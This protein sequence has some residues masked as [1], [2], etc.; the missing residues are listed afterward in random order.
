MDR[1]AGRVAVVTGA[2]GGIGS[3]IAK[4]LVAAGLVV[5]GVDRREQPLRVRPTSR[6]EVTIPDPKSALNMQA[7]VKLVMLESRIRK[8]LGASIP[9]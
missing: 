5:V 1:W 4:D 9:F 7:C 6:Q 8:I 2:A 3:Q